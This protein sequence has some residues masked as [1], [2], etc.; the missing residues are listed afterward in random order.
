MQYITTADMKRAFAEHMTKHYGYSEA[1]AELAARDFPNP[2]NEAFV[3]EEMI[4][5]VEIDGVVYERKACYAD[6]SVRAL[7]NARRFCFYTLYC[8]E[9]VP[10]QTAEEYKVARKLYQLKNLD[11]K[12]FPSEDDI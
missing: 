2:A 11:P 4:D 6:L 9:D 3:R 1:E 5:S 12:D 10:G 8:A 7:D